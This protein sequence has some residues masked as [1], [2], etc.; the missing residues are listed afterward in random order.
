MKVQYHNRHRLSPE[1]EVK[2]N[3]SWCPR[4]GDLLETSDVISISVP[5]DEKTENLISQ[6]EFDRM[7]EGVFLINTARGPVV[8]EEALIKA[9]ESGKVK[10]AGLDVFRGEPSNINE[11]FLESDKVIIQPHLGGLTNR[12]ARDAEAECFT[13]LE[14]WLETG[15]PKA[16]VNE[17]N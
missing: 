2:Y 15:R 13:N 16:P 14:V 1:I 11:W 7:K 9:L 4:L 10:R 5:L 8:D 6:K 17:I 3:A 12:A